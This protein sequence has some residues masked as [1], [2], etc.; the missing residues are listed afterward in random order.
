LFVQM[1]DGMRHI[2]NDRLAVKS[3]GRIY[4]AYA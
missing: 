3:I 2:R 4:T 1:S